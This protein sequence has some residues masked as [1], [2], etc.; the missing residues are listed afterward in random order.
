MKHAKCFLRLVV[1]CSAIIGSAVATAT[2]DDDPLAA[3]GR[4][5]DRRQYEKALKY[6]ERLRAD[7]STADDVR[8][9]LDFEAGKTLNDQAMN[10]SDAARREE[11]FLLA[12]EHLR[13]FLDEHP[14]DRRVL[15]AKSFL[16]NALAQRAR[17]RKTHA[18]EPDVD[19]AEK[20][21]LT[22]EAAE[23]VVRAN[24]AYSPVL[25]GRAQNCMARAAEP[26]ADPAQKQRLAEEA[27]KLLGEA[28]KNLAHSGE[29]TRAILKALPPVIAAEETERIERRNEM[30]SL[31]LQAD[32]TTG[33]IAVEMAKTFPDGSEEARRHLTEAA[34][35]F[36]TL[37]EKYGTRL[38]GQYA[39][40]QKARCYHQ[41]GDD[42]RA[43]AICAELLEALPEDVAAFRDIRE[44]AAS[45]A[46]E[47][48]P[49][50]K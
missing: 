22:R 50:P 37:R 49:I 12:E 10:L 36:G 4:L 32:L 25:I 14:D 43:L 35:L 28:R 6:I 2:A 15:L 31:L 19:P 38:A 3:V 16:A 30:R 42:E 13:Q 21:R 17:M 45:L 48:R 24:A 18:A 26:N 44:Q 39:G 9:G 33:M 34:E 8:Q 7:R 5:R 27:R 1:V 40:L 29:L 47:I 46:R 23:L 41:L 11:L 20:K